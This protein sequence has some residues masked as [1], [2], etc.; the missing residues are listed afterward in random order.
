MK[1]KLVE[2]PPDYDTYNQNRIMTIE[3]LK[4]EVPVRVPSQPTTQIFA[5]DTIPV[6]QYK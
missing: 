5:G 3:D 2:Y 1:P 6:T 4:E